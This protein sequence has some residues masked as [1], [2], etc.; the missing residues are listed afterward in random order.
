MDSLSIVAVSGGMDSCVTLALAAK[1]GRVAAL[2]AGYGQ[3]TQ[4]RELRAFNEICGF[5]NIDRRLIVD[6]EYLRR[7]GGSSLTD[8]SAPVPEAKPRSSGIPSTYVPFRNA[9]LLSVAVSWAEVIDAGFVYIGV[10]EED[11]SGYPDCRV[12]FIESFAKA[13][14]T[15]TKPENNIAIVAPLISKTKAE[16]VRLG[17]ELGAPLHL[18]WSCYSPPVDGA[19]CGA[20]ESCRLRLRGFSEAGAEDPLAYVSGR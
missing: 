12:D 7:I 8:L 5:Y 14:E 9:H 18:T 16:I 11:S 4:K 20:C 2:H 15:G 1:K 3:R 17:L 10:V 13:V 19:A 6:L